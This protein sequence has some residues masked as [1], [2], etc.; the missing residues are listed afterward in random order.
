MRGELIQLKA[1]SQKLK[2][3]SNSLSAHNLVH[4]L[5]LDLDFGACASSPYR[6]LAPSV[7]PAPE[8]ESIFTGLT[9]THVHW[10]IGHG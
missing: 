1:K 3:N 2:A 4:A 6:P 9:R 7:T 10:Y 5:E 8:P